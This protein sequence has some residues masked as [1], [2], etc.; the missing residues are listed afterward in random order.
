MHPPPP[1][2]PPGG[3]LSHSS[4]FNPSPSGPVFGIDPVFN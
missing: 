1:P 2:P 4:L 3:P